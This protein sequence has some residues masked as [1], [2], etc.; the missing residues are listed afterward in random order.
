MNSN[1]IKWYTNDMTLPEKKRYCPSQNIYGC[2]APSFTSGTP[3]FR[4]KSMNRVQE[5][6]DKKNKA[7]TQTY[8][9]L[10][11]WKGPITGHFLRYQVIDSLTNAI[12]CF[13]CI[14]EKH[15]III[16]HG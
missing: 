11:W 6:N 3:K 5:A 9:A 14:F 8:N 1:G 13:Y 10:S 15:R 2:L 16:R 4:S 12:Q 7:K